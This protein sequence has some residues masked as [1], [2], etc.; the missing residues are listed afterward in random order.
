MFA[1]M[2]IVL[3]SQYTGGE[4]VVSHDSTS[5]VIDVSASC[6]SISVLP[7]YTDVMHVEIGTWVLVVL[8]M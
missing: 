1:T 3:P 6:T 5:E 7:W 2:I 4:I 8:N